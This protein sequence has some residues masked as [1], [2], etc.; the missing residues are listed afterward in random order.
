MSSVPDEK[1]DRVFS[2]KR[3][4][5]EDW[6]RSYVDRKRDIEADGEGIG[7]FLQDYED[8]GL[9]DKVEELKAFAG[10]VTLQHLE[11]GAGSAGLRRE[12]WL[13]ERS[14]TGEKRDHKNPF[15]A[16]QLHQRRRI[17]RIGA[18]SAPNSDRCLTYIRNLDASYMLALAETALSHEVPLLRDAIWKHYARQTSLKVTIPYRGYK[19]FQ[20]EFHL[21]FFKFEAAPANDQGMT[22]KTPPNWTDLSF[23]EEKNN[24]KAIGGKRYGMS[25]A[26][27]SFVIC[28]IREG[29]WAG[30]AFDDT[31]SD[32]D[33]LQDKI[34]CG[35]LHVDP[36]GSC[37]SVDD[38]DAELPIWNPREYFLDVVAR[39]VARA[40]DFW[41]ALLR[42]I[43]RRITDHVRSNSYI[44]LRLAYC[45]Y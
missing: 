17:P 32:G 27:F 4:F 19:I 9:D 31:E 36:I 29:R 20:L 37:L 11:Q 40:A 22:T 3:E 30:Y 41:E 10:P 8:S 7:I 21:Q 33:D 35:G 39:R 24:P 43:E 26:H 15:T 2:T 1:W 18:E 42:A 6:S 14:I 12:A 45:I 44:A 16:T 34:L 13:D 28:G 5:K 25:E 38:V 23:L